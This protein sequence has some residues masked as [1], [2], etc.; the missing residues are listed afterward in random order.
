MQR[1]SRESRQ[2]ML[3][4][5]DTPAGACT[6]VWRRTELVIEREVLTVHYPNGAVLVGECPQCGSEVLMLEA[7]LGPSGSTID[8]LQKAEPKGSKRKR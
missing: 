2:P 5:E 4:A 3:P 7:K 8:P 1:N 6:P